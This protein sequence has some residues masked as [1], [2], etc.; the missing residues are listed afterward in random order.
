VFATGNCKRRAAWKLDTAAR[1][2]GR[3]GVEVPDYV[4]ERVVFP[5]DVDAPRIKSVVNTQPVTPSG[6]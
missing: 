4:E 1:E 6:G 3:A 5:Q 2:A